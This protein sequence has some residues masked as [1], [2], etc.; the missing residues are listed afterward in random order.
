LLI[1]WIAAAIVTPLGLAAPDRL[2]AGPANQY[3]AAASP[4]AGA[5]AREL[6]FTSDQESTTQIY[7]QDLQSG[8][9]RLAFDELADVTWPRPSPDGR[10]LLYISYREDAAGDLC[11]REIRGSVGARSFG[12]RRCLTG[13]AS[14]ELQAVWF[15]DSQAIAL[16][17]RPGLHGDFELRRL[18]LGA[19]SVAGP[20][21]GERLAPGSVSS[22]ALSPDGKWLVTVPVTRSSR[23]IGPSFLGKS[24]GALE[25]LRL[26]GGRAEAPRAVRLAFAL[27]GASAM[28][29]F[30]SD[31]KWLYFT[32]FLNDTNFDGSID[33]NDHGVLFRAAFSAA[34]GA[35]AAPEQ[36]SSAAASCQYPAPAADR[37][38]ATCLS[39]GSLDVFSLPPGGAIPAEWRQSPAQLAERLDDELTSSRQPWERLLLLAHRGATPAVWRE[40]I[41]LHL[42][43]GELESA[44]FYAARVAAA[45]PAPGAA[46]RELAEQRR[47][48]RALERGSLSAPFVKAARAR[49][50][51]LKP[52]DHPLAAI[53][54]SEILDT[55]GEE[56]A[57]R[58]A[59]EPLRKHFELDPKA[60]GPTFEPL[61]ASLY[62]ERLLALYRGEPRYFE[63]YQPIA[64]QV[65]S[66]A[67]VFVR[68][69]LRGATAAER[70]ARVDAWQKRVDAYGEIAFL[71]ELE[72]ALAELTAA[73]QEQVRERVFLL[74]RQNKEL[75]RR[76][77]L[78][79]ATV[80]RALV[81]GNEYLLYNFAES[82]ASYVPRQLAERRRAERLYRDAVFE[83]AYVEEARGAIGGARGHFYGV[84]LQTESLEAHAGFLEMRLAEGKD[85]SAD[86]ATSANFSPAATGYARAYLLARKLPGLAR[87]PAAHAKAEAEAIRELAAI[88]KAA[89]QR[90]EVHQLWAY[91]AYQ[92]YLRAGDRLAPMEANAH[93][94]LALDLYRDSPRGRAATLDLLGRVQAAVGNYGLALGWLEA[95]ARLPFASPRQELSHCLAFARARY[96][97]GDATGAKLTAERCTA[98]TANAQGEASRY[99]P[100]ALD[101]AGL[102]ALAAGAPEAAARAYA[103]LWPLV[104]KAT[105]SANAPGEA[106]RNRLT[107][108]L[109]QASAALMLGE[110]ATPPQA[111]D[112][113]DA[114]RLVAAAEAL[115]GD[116]APAPRT[117]PYLRERPPEPLPH[118]SYRLLL[119]GLR[120]QAHAQAGD[121]AAA[122]AVMRQRRD[123][124]AARQGDSGLDEDRLELALCEAQL[125]SYAHRRGAPVTEVLGHLT[126]ARTQWR[127]WSASTGTPVEDL[128]LAIL[129]SLADL[130]LSEGVTAAQL[131]F[132]LAA[133]LLASYT[134]LSL[135]RNPAWETARARF[136]VYLTTLNVRSTGR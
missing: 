90:A 18:S 16:V 133:E 62:A 61:V 46:L 52:I 12:P 14:A 135:V 85:P 28:P 25:L 136:E 117:G 32:Q 94:L 67:E 93:A 107:T 84:T 5:P 63:L 126:R 113:Q 19:S 55:L 80:R 116:T 88:A 43:L 42:G 15:P 121:L 54:A 125:A 115:L 74:Y 109:G 6:Y 100:L 20:V 33:G 106:A 73:T 10:H 86:Y 99:R 8:V 119:L 3:L 38:L 66:H 53:A 50:E 77:A 132:D 30:S 111:G 102:Y 97:T 41:G 36:L 13:D 51:R 22:P 118:Q 31:G 95:R 124:V 40:M 131:G 35:A 96:H 79:A 45:E 9:P 47:D 68:E 105:D 4:P 128:G 110:R 127:A 129:G 60:A 48:E 98:M 78:V 64:E 123:A 17:T 91:I 57:A 44:M 23:Q 81:A 72:R 65:L 122:T 69:L 58:A 26:A 27:P 71:L 7:V 56:T 21:T 1:A 39:Q 134:Q 114:L 49:L 29:A 130:H 2:T 112:A 92:R 101:R 87:D 120:A 108:R 37:L 103:E 76:K 59:L 24:S 83:R 75:P 89:P 104:E 11:V 82:W 70:A 34:D